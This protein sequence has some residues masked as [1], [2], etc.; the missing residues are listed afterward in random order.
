MAK[1]REILLS[2]H[3]SKYDE[4]LGKN[5]LKLMGTVKCPS[6]KKFSIVKSE[7]NTA[8]NIPNPLTA[9][10]LPLGIYLIYKCTTKNCDYEK[11]VLINVEM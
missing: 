1:E 10:D 11:R 7:V 5:R 8:E 3:N 9:D 2:K 6:C 4:Q